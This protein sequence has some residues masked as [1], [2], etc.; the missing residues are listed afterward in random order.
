MKRFLEN[1]AQYIYSKNKD[2]LSNI[3]LVFPNRRSGVFFTSYFQKHVHKPLVSPEIITINE[4]FNGF[5]EYQV[6]DKLQL[7]AILYSVFKKNPPIN[8]K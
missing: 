8:N 6:A 5:T 3:T 1:C 7:I 4:F 2:N